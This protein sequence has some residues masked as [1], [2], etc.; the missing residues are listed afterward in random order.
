VL[1]PHTVPILRF[2]V[3]VQAGMASCPQ[4]VTYVDSVANRM[5]PDPDLV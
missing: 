3:A 2:A 1:L 5:P 4:P